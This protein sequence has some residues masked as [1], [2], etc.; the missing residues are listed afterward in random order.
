[1]HNVKNTLAALAVACEMGID[2]D[3][4]ASGVSGFMG[5]KRRF[6]MVGVVGS[7][8]VVDDYAHH[9][10]EIAAT[11]SAA[12]G[13]G[14]GRIAAVFQP[15]LY[16]RTRDFMD[17]FA[18]SLSDADIV[19]VTDIYKARELPI[20]GVDAYEI[21]N[22]INGIGKAEAYYVSDK[23]DAVKI[24]NDNLD[25]I[26]LA[27]FMGAGDIWETARDFAGAGGKNG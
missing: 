6:E 9:P 26:D 12:R 18:E 22:R 27:I 5:V 15:H 14:Y 24:L 8:A 2:F 25:K 3:C 11:L 1:L 23:S 7:V 16:S 21:V 19:V 17:G 4:A 20:P 10:S 13:G